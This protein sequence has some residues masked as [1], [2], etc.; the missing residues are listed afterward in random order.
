MTNRPEKG[1]TAPVIELPATDTSAVSLGK[2]GKTGQILFFYPKDNTPGCT[3]EAQDF[4]AQKARLADLGY[5]VIG[6][7]RD[8]LAA[9][10]RFRDKQAL[11]VPLASDETGIACEAFGVWVEKKMYGKTF[12]G[13]ERSTFLVEKDGRISEVWRKVKVKGHVDAVIAHIQANSD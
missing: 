8:S 2:P 4:S 5:H 9:H 6:V 13:I 7:S 12:M 10:Q 1:D 3:T 11:T